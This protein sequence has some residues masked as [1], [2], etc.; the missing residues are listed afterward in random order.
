LTE[1][2]NEIVAEFNLA[3]LNAHFRTLDLQSETAFLLN[4]RT[5]LRK[6][7]TDHPTLASQ[8]RQFQF[9]MSENFKSSRYSYS[10]PWNFSVDEVK[11]RIVTS[12]N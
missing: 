11:D 10:L 2:K 5:M 8:L 4:L 12:F 1:L 7:V 3:D 9:I 6:I